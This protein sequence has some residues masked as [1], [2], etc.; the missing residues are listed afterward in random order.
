MKLYRVKVNG[1]VFE[2]ELESV[3]EV[4]GNVQATPVAPVTTPSASTG[5][6]NV[7]APISGKVLSVKVKVGDKVSKG[8]TVAVIEA[9]KLENEVPSTGEGVVKEVKVNN[10]DSV[11]NNDVLIVLG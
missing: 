9:M 1:K 3:S 11:N 6:T 4:K 8:Q 2:V 7:V 5:G 10:G